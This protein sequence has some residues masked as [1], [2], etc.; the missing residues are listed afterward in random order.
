MSRGRRY[1]S[2][3]SGPDHW[4]R[5]RRYGI[6]VILVS[7]QS[8]IVKSHLAKSLFWRLCHHSCRWSVMPIFKKR[9]RSRPISS[10]RLNCGCCLS[11]LK[12]SLG[13][14]KFGIVLLKGSLGTRK[15][16]SCL[17]LARSCR[18][19]MDSATS[20][21]LPNQREVKCQQLILELD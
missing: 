21:V 20:C 8:G 13:M 2:L 16:W 14:H 10:R 11:G 18:W 1:I 6:E 4:V 5:P 19:P 7:Y 12:G 3:H 9:E 15:F 17:L